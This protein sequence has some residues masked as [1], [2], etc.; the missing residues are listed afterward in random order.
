[1]ELLH[2]LVEPLLDSLISTTPVVILEGGRASG[3][4][5][6]CDQ[7]IKQ[8]GWSSR[9][10]LSDP[11]TIETLRLDPHRFLSSQATPCIIDEAQL[12]PTVSVAVKR[13]VDQRRAP[14]Q[15]V[16]TGSARL[17]RDALGGSDPLAGRAVRLRM[18]SLTQNELERRPSDF[19]DRAFGEGWDTASPAAPESQRNPWIGGLPGI[20]GV[21]GGELSKA[22]ER[23]VATYV[24][25]VLPLG[26]AG[27]R[28]DLG[29]LLRTFR[30]FAANSGQLLSLSRAASEL[31]MQAATVRNHIDLLEASFLLHRIEAHRP[32]E[33]RVITAHP[34][35]FATDTGLAAWASRSWAQQPSAALLGSLTESLVAHDILAT[36]EASA[37][38][39]AVRH[40][41]DAR[42]LKEVDLLLAHPEGRFVPIEVKA[43]S[44]VGPS[45]TLGLQAYLAEAGASCARALVIYEGNRVVDLTP[46]NA[47]AQ[48]LAIPRALI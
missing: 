30:Y 25:A 28:A 21:L 7:L 23:E 29:R 9:L 20:S 8:N 27:T 6:V 36:A 10:D 44:S 22:W 35:L 32:A 3:K 45:S 16:L 18:F 2:R 38:R 24:E 14:G 39:I 47:K 1:M 31:T 40:W 11:Q 33:H 4:S 41:R 12:E 43:S 34:R 13:I 46:P 17:G 19:I 26:A 5:T 15:F 42:N 37:D 48:I